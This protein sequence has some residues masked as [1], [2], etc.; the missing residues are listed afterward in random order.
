M[1]NIPGDGD[2]YTAYERDYKQTVQLELIFNPRAEQRNKRYFQ[3]FNEMCLIAI[4]RYYQLMYW[5]GCLGKMADA[6]KSIAEQIVR[7][8]RCN[9]ASYE[10]VCKMHSIIRSYS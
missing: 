4:K 7:V 5:T 1:Y 8:Y 6:F 9:Q 10:E 2:A 3:L